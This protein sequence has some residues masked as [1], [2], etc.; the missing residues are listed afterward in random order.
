V[1]ETLGFAFA[2]GLVAAVNPCGFA[3]LPAYLTLVVLGDERDGPTRTRGV[4]VLRA[5]AATAMMTLGFLVVFGAFGLLV[6]PVAASAQQYL[7]AITVVI[8]VALAG[9]GVWLLSGREL[10]IPVPRL[11]GGAPAAGLRSMA[12][13]GVA[14]AL[15]SL[16]CTVAPFLAVTAGTFRSGDV[17][18]GVAAYAAYAAGMGLLVGVLA[19]AVALARDSV[20]GGLRRALPHV[21]R[22]S[23]ALLV[24]VGAYVAYYGIYEVRLF[25]FGASPSDPVIDAAGRFQ[26]WLVSTVDSIGWLPLAAAL[27]LLVAAGVTL[28][29]LASRRQPAP[30][31]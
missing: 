24:L 22:I 15:A 14:Y 19:V 3:L 18:L 7:P 26:S 11:A 4:A 1:T 28:G 25:N 21:S 10:R 2:A 17:L 27:V 12:V 5:L 31:D 29:R 8:G 6:A 16:S 13:Y 23:G 20:A 30:R 9:L